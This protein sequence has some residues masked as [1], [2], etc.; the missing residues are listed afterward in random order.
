[1]NWNDELKD[2]NTIKLVRNSEEN[3]NSQSNLVFKSF[4]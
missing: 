1:M 2:P 4:K 3:I